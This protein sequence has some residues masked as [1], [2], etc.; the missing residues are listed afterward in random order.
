MDNRFFRLKRLKAQVKRLLPLLYAF[1][2]LVLIWFGLSAHPVVRSMRLS[3]VRFVSPVVSVVAVPLGWMRAGHENWLN[4]W[5][6]YEQNEALKKENQELKQWRTVALQQ[7]I[8]R[9]EL[10]SLLKYIPPKKSTSITARVLAD[11]GGTFARSLIV[12]AGSDNGIKKGM[13]AMTANGIV[14]RVVDV[15]RASSRLMLMTDYLSRIP[16]V[17]GGGKVVCVASGDNLAL[18]KLI[19]V[20]E[21]AA[22]AAGDVVLTSGDAGL[23]PSGLPVGVVAEVTDNDIFVR[24]AESEISE[25]VRLVDFGLDD[26]LLKDE[27]PCPC[28]G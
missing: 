26:V 4:L 20:P 8:E 22:I 13:I 9:E 14:G 6:A 17:V 21:G 23:Y 19:A 16:V 5:N 28:G 1:V 2:S 24:P 12:G 27:S 25:F 15:G 11:N 3:V 18:L 7:A 10:Q